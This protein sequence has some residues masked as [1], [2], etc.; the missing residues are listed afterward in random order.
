[1]KERKV[2]S[3]G[4]EEEVA[5]TDDDYLLDWYDEGDYAHCRTLDGKGVEL[6]DRF[7]DLETVSTKLKKKETKL[8]EM[9]GEEL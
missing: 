1:M 9:F 6:H 7:Y 3:R 2:K 8:L 5:E 4:L